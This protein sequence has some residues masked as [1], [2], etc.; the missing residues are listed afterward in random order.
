MISSIGLSQSAATGGIALN[1]A[2]TAEGSI[3][4]AAAA[5]ISPLVKLVGGVIKPGDGSGSSSN[6][7]SSSSSSLAAALLRRL[8]LKPITL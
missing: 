7:N 1:A 3:A 4:V 5:A 6:T 8:M 2:A